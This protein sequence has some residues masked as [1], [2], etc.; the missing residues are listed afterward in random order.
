[1][2]RPS[3]SA[4]LTR[5]N[6][7]RALGEV[8]RKGPLRARYL[9]NIRPRSGRP[10]FASAQSRNNLAAGL[11]RLVPQDDTQQRAV[12]LQ[13]A[14]VLDEAQLPEFV[15]ELA[16]TGTCRADDLSQC[17]L[18]DRGGDRLR[19]A[20]LTEIRKN[21]QRTCKALFARVEELVDEVLLDPAVAGQQV[22][23]EQLAKRRLGMQNTDHL[24]LA[25]PHHFA[26]DHSACCGQAQRLADQAAFAEEVARPEDRDHR[27]LALLGRDND[28]DLALLDVENGLSRARLQEDDV[29]LAIV[30]HRAAATHRGE[31]RLR[32]KGGLTVGLSVVFHSHAPARHRAG[33]YHTLLEGL[34][35]KA[36]GGS[37][38]PLRQPFTMNGLAAAS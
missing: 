4:G 15:H 13:M 3:P 7:V 16:D 31:K 35:P 37:E 33:G 36:D 2:S 21:E 38:T 17:L 24:G 19:P 5:C 25:D 29:F 10:M 30:G 22:G 18:A 6:M 32:I 28:L 27:F 1:M 14:V 34:C 26:L 12:N 11:R 9:R 8:P 20:V 23:H